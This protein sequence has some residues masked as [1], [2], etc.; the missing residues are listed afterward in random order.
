MKNNS[1]SDRKIIQ[2]SFINRLFF[3][4]AR[5]KSRPKKKS[6]SLDLCQSML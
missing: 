1:R 3:D 5:K 6:F 2:T 4:M